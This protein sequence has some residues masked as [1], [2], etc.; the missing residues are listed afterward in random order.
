V[1]SVLEGKTIEGA[2]GKTSSRSKGKKFNPS[3]AYVEKAERKG[4]VA[5]DPA[6]HQANQQFLLKNMGL[7]GIQFG[8]SV[9]D[10][11]RK[12]HL[13]KCAEAFSDL[14]DVTGIPVEAISINGKLGMAFGARGIANA[15]AHYEP[16]SKVINLSRAG[17][18]GSLAHEWGHFLDNLISGKG[19]G[20]ATDGRVADPDLQSTVSALKNAWD[21]TG[22][23]QQV[24]AEVRG[25]NSGMYRDNYWETNI[26]MFARTFERWVQKKLH[27]AGRENTYLTGLRKQGHVLWPSDQQVDAM[28]PHFEKLMAHFKANAEKYMARWLSGVSTLGFYPTRSS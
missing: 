15:L 22:F 7:R 18:V 3:E 5:F 11:E 12:H 4:G 26:E 25:P 21:T 19:T 13:A 9:T 16:V 23:R 28:A 24:L 17:G 10:Q 1:L 14:A 20:F 6:K 2:F 8:N 27:D